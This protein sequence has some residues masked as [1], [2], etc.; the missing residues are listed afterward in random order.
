MNAPGVLT[1]DLPEDNPL[2]LLVQTGS[3]AYGLATQ[4]SDEDYLGVYAESPAQVYGLA[5]AR[6]SQHQDGRYDITLHPLRKFVS[7]AAAGNPQ[8]TEVLCTPPK[9]MLVRHRIVDTLLERR[10]MFITARTL[11]AYRGYA[12]SQVKR[13]EK[14]SGSGSDYDT[15]V[16]TH[17]IRLLHATLDLLTFGRVLIPL[18]TWRAD[19]IAAIRAGHV[20]REEV[21]SQVANLQHVIGLLRPA[22]SGLPTAVEPS[23]VDALLAEF[24][25]EMF[26]RNGNN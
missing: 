10:D 21:F 2:L 9:N 11:N 7:L 15:K 18:P 14:S 1:I 19:D 13:L 17:L 6:S 23:E 22:P 5:K 26:G 20:S 3:R 25:S 12:A 24:Y 8:A 4:T 16:A